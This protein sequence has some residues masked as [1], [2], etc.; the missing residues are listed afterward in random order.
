MKPMRH[1][2]QSRIPA[3]VPL[4]TCMYRKASASRSMSSTRRRTRVRDSGPAT[5]M[6]V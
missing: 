4:R 3:I 5:L 1:M 2:K 6:L